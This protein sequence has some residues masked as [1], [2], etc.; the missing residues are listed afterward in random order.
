MLLKTGQLKQVAELVDSWSHVALETHSHVLDVQRGESE[1]KQP[2]WHVRLRGEEKET[3]A[4]LFLLG[5][6]TLRYE[7]FF[8][9]APM[10]NSA[11][12]YRYLLKRN[13][14]IYGAAFC[15]GPED[16]ILLAGRLPAEQVSEQELDRILGTLWE[17]TERCFRAAIRFSFRQPA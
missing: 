9:P 14:A 13:K 11:Q 5:Q 12:L 3:F 7:T 1:Q 8:V 17:E 4:A 10:R 16:E 2:L 15:V 6:R